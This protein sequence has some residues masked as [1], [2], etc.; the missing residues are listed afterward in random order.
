MLTAWFGDA[1]SEFLVL[2]AEGC[3]HDANSISPFS[4]GTTSLVH[5]CP[6]SRIHCTPDEHD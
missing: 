4:P 6:S 2:L 3:M 1:F 5:V